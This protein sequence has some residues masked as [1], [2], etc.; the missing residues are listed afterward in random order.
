MLER[1][2]E[3][4]SPLFVTRHALAAIGLDVVAKRVGLGGRHQPD[5]DPVEGACGRGS[6]DAPDHGVAVGEVAAV[7][8]LER[9]VGEPR[10]RF[11]LRWE[12]RW[13]YS[14][15]LPSPGAA[16][17]SAARAAG[18]LGLTGTKGP[19]IPC[20][21]W[22]SSEAK[23]ARWPIPDGAAA[24]CPASGCSLACRCAFFFC[25]LLLTRRRGD[26]HDLSG[27]RQLQLHGRHRCRRRRRCGGAVSSAVRRTVDVIHSA[28]RTGRARA[29]AGRPCRRPPRGRSATA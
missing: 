29:D 25:Q 12:A 16:A 18:L 4:V 13:A 21:L 3:P 23:A 22:P 1:K 10:P 6:V 28:A 20:A 5:F 8:S 2:T 7:M 24:D 17:A 11:S 26:A 9:A 19:P 14:P 27:R 15:S